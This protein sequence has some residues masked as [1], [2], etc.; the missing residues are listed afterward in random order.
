MIVGGGHTLPIEV[1]GLV[2]LLCP[3]DGTVRLGMILVCNQALLFFIVVYEVSEGRKY[4]IRS[5]NILRLRTI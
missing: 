4:W 1:G 3:F 5:Q 2:E